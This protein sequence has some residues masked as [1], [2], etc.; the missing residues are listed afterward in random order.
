[1]EDGG[2]DIIAPYTVTYDWYLA[3][4]P[5]LKPATCFEPG[6]RVNLYRTGKIQPLQSAHSIRAAPLDIALDISNTII[7]TVF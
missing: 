6:N 2:R 7:S 3:L 5:Y 4:S 1:M